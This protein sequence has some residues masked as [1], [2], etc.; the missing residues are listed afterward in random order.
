MEETK[1]V[2][3]AEKVDIM[4]AIKSN[5]E[6]AKSE[7]AEKRAEKKKQREEKKADKKPIGATIKLAAS[8]AAVAAAAASTAVGV[9]KTVNAHGA[10]AVPTINLQL[11][12]AEVNVG[13]EAAVPAMR[14]TA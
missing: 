2:E 13:A 3:K 12:P 1:K 8:Y 6:I 4:K 14:E 10:S 9:M 5:R 7:R 11:V